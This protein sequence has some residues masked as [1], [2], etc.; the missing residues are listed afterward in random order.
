MS[1][2]GGE[3]NMEGDLGKVRGERARCYWKGAGGREEGLRRGKGACLSFS[4]EGQMD[5]DKRRE[6]GTREKEEGA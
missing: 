5:L 4:V 2:G 1:G 3:G 6:R